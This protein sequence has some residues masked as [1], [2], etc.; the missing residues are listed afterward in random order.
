MK[1]GKRHLAPLGGRAAEVPQQAV[2]MGLLPQFIPSLGAA[3][4]ASLTALSLAAEAR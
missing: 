4:S 2:Q 3:V 1:L